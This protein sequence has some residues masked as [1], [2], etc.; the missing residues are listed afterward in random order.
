LT[1]ICV[2][3]FQCLASN[4]ARQLDAYSLISL[5]VE[6]C[7]EHTWHSQSQL[8]LARLHRALNQLKQ[9]A[10]ASL[11]TNTDRERNP[12]SVSLLHYATI[13]CTE[14]RLGAFEVGEVEGAAGVS[15]R[16][17]WLLGM[18][19]CML[20]T[21]NIYLSICIG[22][23]AMQVTATISASGSTRPAKVV[24]HSKLR[25]QQFPNAN[26][27][28]SFLDDV[29]PR[30]TDMTEVGPVG[31]KIWPVLL[32]LKGPSSSWVSRICLIHAMQHK[33]RGADL[34]QDNIELRADLQR[35]SALC[36]AMETRWALALDDQKASERVVMTLRTRTQTHAH[37]HTHSPTASAR[38]RTHP[39]H[40]WCSCASNSALELWLIRNCVN[41]SLRPYSY[42]LLKCNTP[43]SASS[44]CVSRRRCA[45]GVGYEGALV[46]AVSLKKKSLSTRQKEKGYT[47]PS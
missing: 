29:L 39:A 16:R 27:I 1:R 21:I 40:R 7:C 43:A 24:L 20:T 6:T 44:R 31:L 4:A 45:R 17:L 11:P 19:P 28:I 12:A 2:L 37:T 30:V 8:A 15:R 10:F 41:K 9:N 22:L 26:A 36:Q 35:S 23:Y 25:T 18:G 14:G 38:N 5:H 3:T 32:Q 47:L 42:S 13:S 34:T 46:R 33:N